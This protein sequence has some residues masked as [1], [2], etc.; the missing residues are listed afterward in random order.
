M[1]RILIPKEF[2]HLQEELVPANLENLK[3]LRQNMKK[4]SKL[5]Q[6]LTE[7]AANNPYY[8]FL[9]EEITPRLK[10]ASLLYIIKLTIKDADNHG[11]SSYFCKAGNNITAFI[12]YVDTGDTIE[13][14]KIFSL[15][16]QKQP[17]PVLAKDL[18][19][20][21]HENLKTRSVISWEAMKENPAVEQY[22][23]V[24]KMFGL[25]ISKNAKEIRHPKNRSLF[26]YVLKKEYYT[27]VLQ[28]FVERYL[29]T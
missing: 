26:L 17:N 24:C 2:E 27:P 7:P 6:R 12:A 9:V 23:K 25:N 16:D 19:K 21:L 8:R 3:L 29:K 11:F 15:L 18:V 1:K 28:K 4:D 14:V 13:E 10:R 22:N 5:N 20:F